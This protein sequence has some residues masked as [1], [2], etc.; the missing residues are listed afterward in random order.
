LEQFGI[1]R[2]DQEALL[3]GLPPAFFDGNDLVFDFIE[4]KGARLVGVGVAG[5]AA[6]GEVHILAY[7]YKISFRRKP[8]SSGENRMTIQLL[9]K[10]DKFIDGQ[11][12]PVKD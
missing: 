12:S 5:V 11:I 3:A 9:E 6:D 4:G 1:P 8:E 2:F 7:P 10:F